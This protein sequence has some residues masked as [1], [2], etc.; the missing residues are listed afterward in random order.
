M[1]GIS[2]TKGI[3][4]GMRVWAD[5]GVVYGLVKLGEFAIVQSYRQI[6]EFGDVAFTLQGEDSGET[7]ELA[8]ARVHVVVTEVE[9]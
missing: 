9:L 4:A 5:R 1:N 7:F 3:T 8:A 2:G 6:N